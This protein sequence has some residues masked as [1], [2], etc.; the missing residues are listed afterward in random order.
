MSFVIVVYVPEGI[1]MAS[2]S[3]QS[4][5]IGRQTPEGEKLPPI[6]TVAS[7]FTY[8]TFLLERQAVGISVYGDALL[9]GVQ[10]ESHINRFEEESLSSGDS[11]DRV[12]DKLMSY[13][14]EKFAQAN[15]GFHVAGFKK[16]ARIST[17]HVYICH[18]RKNER[19]RV[20]F[21]INANRVLY[22]CSWGGE[23]DIMAAILKPAPAPRFPVVYQ[24][25]NLQDAIDFAIYA[26]RTTI[27]TM[28]FQVRPKDVGGP[29]D[30]LL[31]TPE[32]AR[33]IQRKELQGERK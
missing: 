18:I 6:Q 13:F 10:M 22:G 4:V 5:T 8:K 15:T 24:G 26:V 11:V 2:D 25:M 31:L 27:D 17:P 33:W 16:E 1:V 30:V 3:R 20:N 28:R 21:D 23:G 12:V 29:I 19:N 7:D 9:G 14:K 32:E